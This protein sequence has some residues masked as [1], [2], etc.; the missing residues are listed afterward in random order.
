MQTDWTKVVCVQ[1]KTEMIITLIGIPAVELDAYGEPYNLCYG[2]VATC[3]LCMAQVIA[4]WGSPMH[5]HEEKFAVHLEVAKKQKN[6][7]TLK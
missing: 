2:D 3:P 1:C 6:L 4:R 7:V 5:R